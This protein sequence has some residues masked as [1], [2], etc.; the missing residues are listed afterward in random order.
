MKRIVLSLLLCLAAADLSATCHYGSN[1]NFEGDVWKRRGNGPLVRPD[2]PY[3]VMICETSSN[4]SYEGWGSCQTG[5]TKGEYSGS[6]FIY[7]NFEM[8]GALLG[9]GGKSYWVFTWADWEPWGSP[10][11]PIAKMTVPSSISGTAGVCMTIYVPPAPTEPTPRTPADGDLGV[12]GVLQPTGLRSIYFE[13]DSGI[14]AEAASSIWPVAY[15]LH[16]KKWA[17]G[18][19]EPTSYATISNLTCN[20]AALDRCF[21]WLE[22]QDTGHY[23]WYVTV[24]L[25]V[26]ASTPTTGVPTVFTKVASPATFEVPTTGRIPGCCR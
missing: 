6:S 8:F 20:P 25:N 21:F 2:S 12:E 11:V 15:D 9:R 23:K 17:F 10:T 14:R 18:Q 7:H 26:S 4:G 13:W 24:K 19:P 3:N 16:I 22:N 5:R 1:G